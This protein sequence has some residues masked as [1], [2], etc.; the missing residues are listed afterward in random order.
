M[1]SGVDLTFFGSFVFGTPGFP[2]SDVPLHG[3]RGRRGGRPLQGEAV[4][5]VPFRGDPTP[6]PSHMDLVVLRT[7][8][9]AHVMNAGENATV[10]TETDE[11]SW[12]TVLEF[13]YN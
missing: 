2:L 4:A 12:A 11:N 3:D 8:L 9:E 10:G 5:R 13:S 1:A 7:G 6:V